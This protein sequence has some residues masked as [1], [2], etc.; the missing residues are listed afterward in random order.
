MEKKE[1][2]EKGSRQDSHAD[3][4]EERRRRRVRSQVTAYISLALMLLIVAGGCVFAVKY[5]TDKAGEKKPVSDMQSQID[6]LVNSESTIREPDPS[7]FIPELT[8]EEKLDEIVNAAI[9]VMPLEDKIAGLF[10]V[11][12]E[13]VTGVETATQAGDGTKDALNRYAVGGIVYFK[14]NIKS[15]EQIQEMISNTVLYS[16]YPLF[17]AVDE[18]GGTVSRVAESGIGTNVGNASDIGAGGDTAKA[19]EAGQTVAGY[20]SPLGFNLNFAP[21]ADISNVENSVIGKRSFS[22]DSAVAGPMVAS[23]VQG[24]EENGVSSCLKHFPGI[25]SSTEDTHDGL[26]ET[27]RTEEEFRAEEFTVFQ[28][29]IDA[30]AD[31]VMITHMAAPG[32]TGDKTPCTFSKTVVTDILRSQ[33]NFNGVIITDALNMGAIKDY[34][35]AD[36]AAIKAIKAG[37]DMLLM[38]EDFELAYNAVLQAVQDGTISEE[39]INDSLRRIYRI[40]YADKLEQ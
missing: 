29:G 18:E 36:E 23:V 2:K 34:Y 26:A 37:C 27:G 11:T 17:V 15:A 16:R 22:G 12:P 8:E 35:S 13:A 38:P 6:D 33:L 1:L 39:R 28:S 24:L 14:K 3:R 19:Y 31:F 5:I 9:E 25:G 21:V 20:L 40:K 10:I 32:L 30:G 4:R 7:D